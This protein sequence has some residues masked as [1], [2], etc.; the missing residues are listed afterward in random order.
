MKK[1]FLNKILLII[2]VFLLSLGQLQRV[3]LN[4]G[5][6]FYFHDVFILLFLITRFFTKK[7][8][9]KKYWNHPLIKFSFLWIFLGWCFAIFKNNFNP[10]AIL[11]TL[12]LLAYFVFSINIKDFIEEDKELKTDNKNFYLFFS[13]LI[14][15]FGFLQYFLLPDLRFL[16]LA[17]W[18]DH[19]YRLVSTIYDPGFTGLIFVFAIAYYLS[20]EK[21]GKKDWLFLIAFMIALLLT[22][23]RSAYVALIAVLLTFFWQKKEKRKMII[24][25]LIAFL[26]AL[27]FLPKKS[28]GEGVNLTRTFSV[29]AR[30]E[31]D[32]DILAN[33][34]NVGLVIGH[35]FFNPVDNSP[36]NHSHFA[37]SW[38]VFMI[39]NLGIL[40]SLIFLYLLI[41]ELFKLQKAK[42]TLKLALI[43]ALLTHSFFN[44]NLSQSF[45]VLSF[46]GFY[47]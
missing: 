6:A 37:D 28:G 26:A 30:L 29:T 39:S 32:R 8:N 2:F 25:I 11:Y 17:G 42:E 9:I 27:P 23:A 18:D 19:Y 43:L 1:S 24:V 3:E 15:F 44:N 31:H 33:L 46:L 10:L 38:P 40:G 34:D 35:G 13:K 20:F 41:K 7:I 4:N 22:Y 36:S 21:R 47:L 5:I 16:S 14:L 45:I 12:R